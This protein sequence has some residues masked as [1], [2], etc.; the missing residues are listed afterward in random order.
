M[1]AIQIAMRIRF[2]LLCALLLLPAAALAAE[3]KPSPPKYAGVWASPDCGSDSLTMIFTPHYVLRSTEATTAF[4]AVETAA[5]HKDY[6]AVTF[7]GAAQAVARTEDGLLKVGTVEDMKDW[8]ATWD[9]L[10]LAGHSEYSHCDA[11]SPVVPVPLARVMQKIE[12]VRDACSAAVTPACGK[13]LFAMADSN[14]N[15]RLSLSEF[16]KTGAML[17]T[18]IPLL[19]GK[20]V[21]TADLEAGYKQGIEDGARVA[22]LL[23]T[24]RDR[25]GSNDLDAK[26]M[27]GFLSDAPDPAL[28]RALRALGGLFPPFMPEGAVPEAEAGAEDKPEKKPEPAEQLKALAAPILRN[29]KIENSYRQNQ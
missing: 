4:S 24:A 5:R 29:M 2:L 21:A 12:A 3:K 18:F 17:G 22:A 26:E 10:D 1:Y 27:A 13:L 7:Q 9:G 23:L 8:P 20:P 14:G 19:A 11:V 25:D 6:D 15:K 16:K 28:R